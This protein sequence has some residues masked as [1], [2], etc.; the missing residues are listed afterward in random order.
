MLFQESNPLLS[1][2]VR[3]ERASIFLA[4]HIVVILE[5]GPKLSP[6]VEVFYSGLPEGSYHL[7][8]NGDE[9]YADRLQTYRG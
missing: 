9:K 5:F 2:G 6:V 3:T 7:V 1:H 4:D 8:T